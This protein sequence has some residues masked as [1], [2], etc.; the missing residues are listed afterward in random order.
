MRSVIK[1]ILQRLSLKKMPDKFIV[2]D[3]VK[4][5]VV[6]EPYPPPKNKKSPI[7]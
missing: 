2:V 3:G 4:V 7:S 1:K 6:A 5:R